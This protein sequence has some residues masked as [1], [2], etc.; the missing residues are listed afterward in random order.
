MHRLYRKMRD[1]KSI[2]YCRMEAQGFVDCSVKVRAISE[3]FGI[4]ERFSR[5]YL[6]DDPLEFGERTRVLA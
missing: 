5:S 6:V 2:A 3:V 4:K 1:G